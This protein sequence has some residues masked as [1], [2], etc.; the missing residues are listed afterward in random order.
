MAFYFD[1]LNKH[2]DFSIYVEISKETFLF[3]RQQETRWGVEPKWYIEHVWISHL[4]FGQFSDAHIVLSGENE[5]TEHSFHE[6]IH[7]PKF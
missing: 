4:I 5:W 1:E 2:Y 6:I 3:R 7:H